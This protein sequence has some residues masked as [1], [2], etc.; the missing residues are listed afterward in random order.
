MDESSK[1]SVR[2][3]RFIF[4]RDGGFVV[5]GRKR[6]RS[7]DAAEEA[8]DVVAEVVPSAGAICGFWTGVSRRRAAGGPFLRGIE[9]MDGTIL[10]SCGLE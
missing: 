1:G 8:A 4:R 2:D 10:V 9:F 7:S 6:K 3:N 5:K